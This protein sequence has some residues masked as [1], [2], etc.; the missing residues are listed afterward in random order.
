MP[1]VSSDWMRNSPGDRK[2]I[3]KLFNVIKAAIIWYGKYTTSKNTTEKW[4]L[5][6]KCPGAQKKNT[7]FTLGACSC[8]GTKPGYLWITSHSL[9]DESS[10]SGRTMFFI[11]SPRNPGE[12][13]AV[14]AFST[15]PRYVSTSH[16]HKYNHNFP[17]P[18]PILEFQHRLGMQV[19]LL[20]TAELECIFNWPWIRRNDST[21]LKKIS[22]NVRLCFFT[23]LSEFS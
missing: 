5:K 3:K 13:N 17:L 18:Q 4:A 19:H 11:Q 8:N 14:V 21:V 20:Q 10:V 6:N 7:I 23:N 15:Q 22:T 16:V 1:H 12:I 9:I 2:G